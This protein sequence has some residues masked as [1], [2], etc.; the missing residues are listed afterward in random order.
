VP[1]AGGG[2]CWLFVAYAG[3]ENYSFELAKH[4]AAAASWLA[5]LHTSCTT[6]PPAGRV[7]DR[8]PDYYLAQLEHGRDGILQHLS[9]PALEQS[10][11]EVLEEI[12][13]QCEI[14]ALRWPEVERICGL[15]P[16]AFVHGDFAPKNIRIAGDGVADL[17]TFD[18]ANGGWGVPAVDLPQADLAPSTYWANPDLE[19]YLASVATRWPQLTR[20][21]LA[22]NAAV[23]KLLRSVV[24]IRLEA[25]GL[26]TNWPTRTMRRMRHYHADMNDGFR[27]LRW[28]Q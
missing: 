20:D 23:G 12:V 14:L 18:W 16:C 15:I 3:K 17:L 25:V 26:G 24:C 7:S 8:S 22:G 2:D 13:R 4:R 11:I 6:A 19:V 21:H 5:A 9:N 27:A 10:E 28:D 1:D